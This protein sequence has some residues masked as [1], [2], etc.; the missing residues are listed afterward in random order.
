[1]LDRQNHEWRKK[2]MAENTIFMEKKDGAA[3]ITINRP[4][5]RNALSFDMMQDLDTAVEAAASDREVRAILV[6][7]EGKCFSSGIDVNSL[8]QQ[9]I[10]GMTGAEFRHMLYKLQGIL[11][12]L[13]SVEKPVIALLHTYCYG[14]GLELALAADFRIAAEG[15]MI[16][17]QEVELGLVPDV[18]GT[19]RLVRTVGIPMAKEIIMMARKID[20]RRAYEINLVNEI[21]PE[22]QLLAAGMKWVE[23]IKKCAPLAVGFAKKIIDRGAHMDKLSLMEL[24]AYA[25][26]SLLQTADVKEGVMARMQKRQPDFKGK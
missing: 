4:D 8:A 14:M 7:G 5:K 19:T 17:L 26:S 23:Q 11:N 2:E 13:E 15:T 16:A 25:Q 10:I 6:R 20:A 12:R 24:E 1:M 18:G 9:G 21:V 22:D 3:I